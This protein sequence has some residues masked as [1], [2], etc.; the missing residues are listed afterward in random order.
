MRKSSARVGWG[1]LALGLVGHAAGVV[2]WM[3]NG[4]L[5]QNSGEDIALIWL[6]SAACL[7]G[8]RSASM[9]SSTG[10]EPTRTVDEYLRRAPRGPRAAD[11][12]FRVIQRSIEAFSAFASDLDANTR[13]Q[14]D[15][16]A[17]T[18]EVLKQG[19]YQPMPVEQQ[20]M[21]IFAVTNGFLDDVAVNQVRDWELGFQEFMAARY[22]Q[23]GDRI[24]GEKAL[25]KE[26]EADLRR[27][28]EDYKRSV[29]N[30]V[31]PASR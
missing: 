27:G 2:L 24:R 19:Q 29:G 22:P 14:L 15:R 6:S 5:L 31:E 28:I 26:I 4:S 25:S 21:I 20:V 30:A 11:A 12:R 18:V 10:C 16:G 3:V 13:R 7:T 23:V 1:L 8:S 9:K 17:R